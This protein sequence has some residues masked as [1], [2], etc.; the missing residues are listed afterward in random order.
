MKRHNNSNIRIRNDK[1]AWV[2]PLDLFGQYNWL[3]L[4]LKASE[5]ITIRSVAP[6]HDPDKSVQPLPPSLVT[7]SVVQADVHRLAAAKTGVARNYHDLPGVSVPAQAPP[8]PPQAGSGGGGANFMALHSNPGPV[9]FVAYET[10]PSRK[11]F[12]ADVVD[13]SSGLLPHSRVVNGN[14][15]KNFKYQHEYSS[16]CCKLGVL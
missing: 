9:P 2:I 5:P 12:G 6:G 13:D 10:E 16:S 14:S 15:G 11:Y 4:S 3:G 7:S 1:K 8:P